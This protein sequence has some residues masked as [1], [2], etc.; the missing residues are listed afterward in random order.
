MNR[1]LM[2]KKLKIKLV[3]AVLISSAISLSV[4]G[5]LQVVGEKVLNSYL[6]KSAFMENRQ[7]DALERFEEFVNSKN[8]STRDREQ[9]SEWIN[10]ERYLNLYIF[11]KEKLIFSSNKEVDPAINEELLTRF[12]PSEIPTTVHFADQDAQIYLV[13][14]Y[15]Y[16]YYNLI[17]FIG[18]FIAAI[19]FIISFLLII[20]KKTSY[21]GVLEQEI[22]IL[23]GGNLDYSI[24][25]SGKDELSSLAQSID[26]MRK[27]FAERLGSEERMRMAN[28]ELITAISHDLRTPLTILLGYMDIIELNKYK[29]H[30]DLL[31]YIH[32]SREKAYQI[33]A[34]SDKL[35]EYFTVS[36]AAEEEEVEFELYEGRA[37]IDQLIDEQLVV[38]DNLDIQVQADPYD[39]QFLLEINLVAIRRVFDN[40]FSNIRK[41]ADPKHPILIQVSLKQ[42]WVDLRFENKILREAEKEDS[43][44]IGLVSCQK[45]IQKH[46]GTLNV[47]VRKDTFLLQVTL[48]VILNKT[49]QTFE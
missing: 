6:S 33:K 26:E 44:K 24:T 7:Q 22:K 21:I 40:I 20:N 2:G 25:V 36:S 11:A 9:L 43:N 18:I 19:I 45:I 4:F 38:M 12:T 14:L 30:E 5:I 41:Y 29:T 39:E 34:L 23:E 47:S 10:N 49:A 27:S 46:N 48:P 15:E 17:L 13:G 37:L 42:Q 28:R 1:L 35:F 16:Q 31:Q 32:N 8:V 3:L